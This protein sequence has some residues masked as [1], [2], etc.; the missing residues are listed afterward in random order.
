MQ[1]YVLSEHV[2]KKTQ[3]IKNNNNKTSLVTPP[4]PPLESF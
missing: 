3:N 4:P 1:F 2:V